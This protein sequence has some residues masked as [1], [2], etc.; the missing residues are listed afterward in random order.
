VQSALITTPTHTHGLLLL[1]LLL[2]EAYSLGGVLSSL[3]SRS[4]V[5]F[6]HDVNT[7]A[8]Y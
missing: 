8:L 6:F 7:V 1:L 3:S 2:L 4:R 5:S